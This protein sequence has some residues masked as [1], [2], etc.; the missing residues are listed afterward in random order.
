MGALIG[1]LTTRIGKL[2]VALLA[3]ATAVLG[4]IQ[5]GKKQQRDEDRVDDLESFV[6]TKKEIDDVEAATD[7]DAAFE[8]MRRNGLIR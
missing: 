2:L 3:G 7:R 1:L 6:E 8:R 4:L 5:L